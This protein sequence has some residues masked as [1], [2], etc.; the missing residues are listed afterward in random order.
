MIVYLDNI[1][2]YTEDAGQAHIDAVWWVFKELRKYGLFAN[3]KKCWFYKDEVQFLG[4]VVSAQG[5][6][7]KDEKIKAVKNWPKPKS[8]KNIQVFRSFA[9]FYW[10]FIQNFSKIAGPLT[11]MLRASPTQSAKN[12]SLLVDV[13]KNAEVGVGVSDCEDKTVGRSPSK[14]LN[15]ATSYLTPNAR[16]TFTQLR[17]AFTEASILRHFDPKCHIQIETNASGY[18]IGGV[19][20]Q[21]TNSGQ[22]HSVA[23]YLQKMILAKTWY[24]I[25]NGELLAIVEAFKTWRYYLK[26]CKHKLFV[27]T[28]QNNLR[29]SMDTKSLSFCQVSWAQELFCY[30]FWI[31]Y[32]Q[33]KING[34]ADALSRFLQTSLDEKEKL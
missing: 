18:A 28:D 14:N 22:W 1:L 12:L 24:K 20:S 25:Y 23:Y 21:L 8:L 7:M 16:Q 17:Q 32:C 30:Y 10:R 29:Q 31:N 2:I 6:R 33:G 4:Y 15:G 11:S 34:A 3:L 13:A 5:V 26:G 27:F 9:N 19:L